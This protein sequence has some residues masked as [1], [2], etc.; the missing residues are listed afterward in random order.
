[1]PSIVARP[2]S[3]AASEAADICPLCDSPVVEINCKRFCVAC[4]VLVGN[5]AGD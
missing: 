4:G 3:G 2:A 5:C 1:M